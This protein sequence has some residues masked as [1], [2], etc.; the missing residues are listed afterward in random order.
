MTLPA[1]KLVSIIS[2]LPE[3]EVQ[4]DVCLLY[5]SRISSL[6][7]YAAALIPLKKDGTPN[8]YPLFLAAQNASKFKKI[9]RAH[10]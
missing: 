9:G 4:V 6:P 1:K 5:T 7:S 8:A 3:A 2:E 10:V